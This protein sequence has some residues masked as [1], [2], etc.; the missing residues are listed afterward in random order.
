MVQPY[1]IQPKNN[2]L[3]D[4]TWLPFHCYSRPTS[5]S[6]SGLQGL[7]LNSHGNWGY[8]HCQPVPVQR[9]GKALQDGDGRHGA[10]HL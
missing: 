1:E 3:Q 5:L 9:L 7:Y 6:L 8:R 2:L 10:S 4:G